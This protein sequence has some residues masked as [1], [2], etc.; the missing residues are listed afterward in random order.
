MFVF[1]A[2]DSN[3]KT[4][5]RTFKCC[6]NCRV[7]RV[8]CQ[9][10]ST[11]YESLGCVNCRKNK[12]TCSLAKQQAV[13]SQ[14]PDQNQNQQIQIQ[15]T[16][17]NELGNIDEI[18]QSNNTTIENGTATTNMKTITP[19]Y[20]KQTFNFN[21]SGND[22]GSNY[23]Y[24]FHGHPKVIIA[25]S[26]DQ[27]IWHE[28]G[29][30]VKTTKEN[31][32]TK[33]GVEGKSYKL[34]NFGS[35]TFKEFYIRN[36]NVYN[37]LL[38][39]NAFT[40]ES[41]AYPFES[42]EV[43]Q[44]I[45]LY[46]Y[47]LNS[48]F[49]LVHENGFWDDYRNNK[50]QNVLIYVVVLAISR[51]KMAESI[52]KKVFLRGT[53]H[54]H[55]QQ[56]NEDLVSF[57]SELEYKIRQILLILPQLGDED[58]FSRLVVSLVLSTHFNYDKLG[59][60]NSSHDLT[61]A[62]NLA[63]SIGIHMKRLSLNAEPSK[64]EYSSNL[65]W[66]CYIFDRFNGLVNARPVFIRQEDFNVDLPYNN[67]NL[68]KMVQ[69][70]RSLENMF[71]AIFQP[72]NN[73]NVI[74]TNNL[75]NNMVRYKMFDTDEFQRIEFELCDK[76]RSRNRVAYDSMYPVASRV[77]DNP[78]TDYVGNTIHFMTRVV[79][80]VII[81]ASQK[82]KYDNPQ[83][84]NHIPEAVALRASSNILWY[85]VQMKD[86]FVINIPMVP[87][88][89]SLAMAVA[90]KKKARMCLKDGE[91]EEY[92]VYQDPFEF[93]DYINELEKFSSTWWVVDEICRLTRDF[94]NT[95]DSKSKSRKRRQRAKAASAA[96]TS[97]KKQK[98]ES[99]SDWVKSALPQP[100]SSPVPKSDAIP[101]IRNMLQ[102][103]SQTSTELNAYVAST[104]GTTPY[105]QTDS[106]FS[107]NS[108]NSSDA[109]QYDQYFESMQ[110]D[111]FNNDFFKD[112]PNVI[113]LLK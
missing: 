45:E 100:V 28:S 109:N 103:P 38:S 64:V 19:Q 71:F 18:S 61:D 59:C 14:T 91:Y 111:I 22:S 90:L 112:V 31:Q 88:C 42:D 93:K 96:G 32:N 49:P 77:G 107:P 3:Y 11:D 35:G 46:F 43:R 20:L 8:K 10:T 47:K 16:I 108:M 81:L 62:I 33:E 6:Q 40:L 27:T 94:T 56:F 25:M 99:R 15:S 23:Q 87:W 51:D 41:P 105:M 85:L 29:V 95:L 63:T 36:E 17:K 86:E 82:A 73:N 53:L 37:F 79:N 55:G 24:L 68:L 74:G 106:S 83:I 5:K 4:R 54:R 30:Y 26:D 65:W 66:C 60:E 101:S 50:A 58:K 110:I 102:P 80:N 69:L 1:P 21:V 97:K 48:I 13:Q 104:N 113:N 7:K 39:I 70:A 72:F 12:W 57:M 34:K 9:I 75:N 84:P 67:I 52:L 44:L 89:M 2:F 92:K 78:F 98:M 76:E